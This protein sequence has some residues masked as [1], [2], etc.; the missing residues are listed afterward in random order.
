MKTLIYSDPA[1]EERETDLHILALHIQI[2][3]WLSPN[4]LVIDQDN[5]HFFQF[6][7]KY[8]SDQRYNPTFLRSNR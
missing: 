7:S 3:F 8:I 1:Q 6:L 4:L 5:L 2:S